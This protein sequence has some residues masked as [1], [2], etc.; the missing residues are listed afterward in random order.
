MN[1]VGRG[2]L[3]GLAGALIL[4]ALMV[5]KSQMGIMP[6]LDVIGMISMMMGVSIGVAW[7]IHFMIGAVWGVLFGATYPSVPGSNSLAKGSA[8]LTG[9]WLLMM[10]VVMPMAGGGL[11]GMN[12]G[13]MAPVMTLALHL[14]FGLVMGGTFSR[15]E[16]VPA[17][18]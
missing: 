12:L 11:F 2:I 18:V 8:F 3:A 17:L 7:G 16:R 9:A 10:V 4:S 15:T 1:Y 14:I 5:M 13:I 6:E